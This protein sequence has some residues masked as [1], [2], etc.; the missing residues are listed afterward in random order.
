MFDAE[1]YVGIPYAY[2]GTDCYGLVQR[3]YQEQ[4]NIKLN[5]YERIRDWSKDPNFVLRNLAVNEGFLKTVRE[6]L[7]F[8][9]LVVFKDRY[10][11]F[12]VHMSIYLGDN[13]ILV[14]TIQHGGSKIF[15]IDNLDRDM[16]ITNFF[17]HKDL[18]I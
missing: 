17:T 14:S 9:D 6:N 13:K 5:D 15:D 10:I 12:P 11:P 1:Q 7:K 4:F 3:F 18:L 8:G 16:K 2:G